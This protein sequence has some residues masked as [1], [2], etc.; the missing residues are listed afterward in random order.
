MDTTDRAIVRP[1]CVDCMRSEITQL[2]PQ[3]PE[4]GFLLPDGRLTQLLHRLSVLCSFVFGLS[5]DVQGNVAHLEGNKVL[6]PVGHLFAMYDP[7]DTQVN[8]A[9]V[10]RTTHARVGCCGCQQSPQH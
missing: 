4:P 8:G 1:R 7:T 9:A 2:S 5:R 10:G 3:Q 6:F